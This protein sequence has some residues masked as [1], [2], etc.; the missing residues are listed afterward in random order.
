MADYFTHFSCLLDVGTP[1]NAARAV[2]LYDNTSE[3]DDGLA[4]R[5]VSTFQ[6]RAKADQPSGF[7]TTAREIP[8]G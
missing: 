2:E 8:S 4:S 5:T 3:D 6:S 7:T 1:E